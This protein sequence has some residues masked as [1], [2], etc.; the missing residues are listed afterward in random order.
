MKNKGLGRGINNFIK[1]SNAVEKLLKQ[2]D[3]NDNLEIIDI[4]NIEVNEMQARKVFDKESLE[5]LAESIKKYGIIQ[6]IILRKNN[7]KYTIVAGE[8]RYRAAKSIDLKEIPAV[9]RD[10]SEE[11]AD[12]ISLIENI[13]RQDLN[14]IEEA[15]GYKRVLEA[16]G[17]T[18]EELSKTL[19]KSR[20]Y[21]GNTIRLLRLDQ[22][23]LD[24]MEKGLL[25]PSHGKLLLSIKDKDEQYR[26]AKKIIE[27][28]KTV[29]QT[30]S[31]FDKKK[32]IDDEED[33][34][35]RRASRDLS[36]ALGTKVMFNTR[37]KKKNIVIEYYNDDDLSRIY[38]RIIGSDVDEIL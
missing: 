14:P 26:Q 16:Y 11:D 6:P 8:R 34:F 24:F 17:L 36:N 23:V 5:E 33:I 31:S 25:T 7:D 13:Q 38:E 20:Q 22:R 1:D 12:K 30:R 15:M 19:G 4:E 37:G 10:I 18:Q 28:G 35:I 32:K 27:S 29:K 3:Y 9:V 21:I 2:D